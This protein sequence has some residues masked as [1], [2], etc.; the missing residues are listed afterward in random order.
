M[1]HT[2]SRV[3]FLD[4]EFGDYL[5]LL[6]FS[7]PTSYH[8]SLATISH[9]LICMGLWTEPHGLPFIHVDPLIRQVLIHGTFCRHPEYNLSTLD[10]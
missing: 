1:F 10:L 3:P 5:T 4:C 9:K 8:C 2:H 6:D 7:A